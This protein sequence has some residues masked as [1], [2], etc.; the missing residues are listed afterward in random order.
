MSTIFR[1]FQMR[2]ENAKNSLLA[3][4]L[5]T[6]L[7]VMSGCSS[8]PPGCADPETKAL[9]NQMLTERVTKYLANQVKGDDPD[10][11]VQKYLA[12]LK[13]ELTEIVAE[14]YNEPARK[15]LCRAKLTVT[16]LIGGALPDTTTSSP[17]TYSTQKMLDQKDAFL[18]SMQNFDQLGLAV[19]A[20]AES[21][22]WKQRAGGIWK[23]T[24]ACSGMGGATDGPQGPYSSD[25]E[26]VTDKGTYQGTLERV[27]KGGGVEKIEGSIR[28]AMA[29]A[30]TIFQGTGRNSP[31][32]YW[33]ARFETKIAGSSL[34]A[35]GELKGPNGELLRQ[36]EIKLLHAKSS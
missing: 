6:A 26:M 32:D 5:A 23:G 12:G 18:L 27:T 35:I 1:I 22:F 11:I 7:V 20:D 28:N 4:L 33:K 14:G 9:A 30:G 34:T 16:G 29:P 10:G 2:T 21:Y 13:A 36:C 25:V 3:V 19:S 24:Y 31:D 8:K 17:V 15:Q